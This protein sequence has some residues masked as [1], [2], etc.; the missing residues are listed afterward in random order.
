MG[1]DGRIS[2]LYLHRVSIYVAGS[3]ETSIVGFSE[4][5]PLAGLLGRRGFLDRF[6]FTYD[7]STSPP[8]FEITKISRA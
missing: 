4:E 7:C 1:I 3:I 2:K 6:R 8:Q 5:V